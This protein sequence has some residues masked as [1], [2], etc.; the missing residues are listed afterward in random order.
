[1]VINFVRLR[2]DDCLRR[3]EKAETVRFTEGVVNKIHNVEPQRDLGIGSSKYCQKQG[4]DMA[5]NREIG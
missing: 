4:R 3:A 2:S 5:K 1:M